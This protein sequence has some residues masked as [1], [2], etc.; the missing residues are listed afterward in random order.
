MATTK[1]ATPPA[2]K[3]L[4]PDAPTLTVALPV[5]CRSRIEYLYD[6]PDDVLALAESL[7][8]TV[9]G[10]H[11]YCCYTALV[12]E[13]EHRDWWIIAVEWGNWSGG[14]MYHAQASGPA[15]LL[16]DVDPGTVL[17]R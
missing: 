4:F 2:R 14:V 13:H 3:T 6:R 5:G 11:T 15:P 1:A 10:D 16:V 17:G 8:A 7:H 9:D 12:T